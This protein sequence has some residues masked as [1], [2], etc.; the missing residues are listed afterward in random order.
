VLPGLDRL[1]SLDD[2]W[3]GGKAVP[4]DA[5]RLLPSIGAQARLN[6]FP[7]QIGAEEPGNVLWIAAAHGAGGRACPRGGAGAAQCVGQP[8]PAGHTPDQGGRIGAVAVAELEAAA[9]KLEKK[10]HDGT[11]TLAREVRDY[12]RA[13][14]ESARRSA[15]CLRGSGAR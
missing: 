6:A 15:A 2:Q 4:D 7:H 9:V 10:A 11:Y 5:H 8:V 1:D 14:A 13:K 12:Y 3:R